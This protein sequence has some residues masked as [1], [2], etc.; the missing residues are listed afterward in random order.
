MSEKPQSPSPSMSSMLESLGVKSTDVQ[1]RTVNF[2]KASDFKAPRLFKFG[3]SMPEEV[4]IPPD[5]SKGQT[6][7]TFKKVWYMTLTD[8]RGGHHMLAESRQL[9]RL[10]TTKALEPG[11]YIAMQLTETVET[12]KGPVNRWSV[13]V[14]KAAAVP[15]G[16]GW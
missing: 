10:R 15:K 13:K 5:R 11:D 9:A 3:G 2:L 6:E 12:P 16:K 14:V 7:T 8:E 1:D 4:E